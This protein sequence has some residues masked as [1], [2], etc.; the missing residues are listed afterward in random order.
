MRN[1]NA[2]GLLAGLTTTLLA[3]H[4]AAAHEFRAG[5]LVIQQPWARATP[6]GAAVAGGYFSVTNHGRTPER[7]TGASLEA[8][9]HAELHDMAVENGVMR[10][11]PTGPLA[12]PPEATL[13][14]TPTAKHVMFTGLK[15]GLKAGEVIAGTLTFEHA[16]A[17]PVAFAVEGIGAKQSSDTAGAAAP[18]VPAMKMN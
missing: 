9:A 13:T 17:V 5:D 11:R 16:G 10:M 14:L 15:R 6:G 4:G 18:A 8:A 3:W 7:L 2:A 12:I 1:I